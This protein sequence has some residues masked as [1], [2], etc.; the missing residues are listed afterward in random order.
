MVTALLTIVG[1]AKSWLVA[2]I[3]HWF[4]SMWHA[5]FRWSPVGAYARSR[6]SK[7]F[8]LGR[9]LVTAVQTPFQ[10]RMLAGIRVRE[11][12][13]CCRENDV[14]NVDLRVDP[15]RQGLPVNFLT[16]RWRVRNCGGVRITRVRNWIR[17]RVLSRNAFVIH[18]VLK[19]LLEFQA[20]CR[21]KIL[22]FIRVCNVRLLH[23]VRQMCES[24][25]VVSTV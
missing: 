5:L 24:E 23:Y 8:S 10:M 22:H 3:L 6:R 18:V 15:S 14:I 21:N 17:S 20:S 25:T 2:L 9:A 19:S 13:R 7:C 16:T 11:R 12:P 1:S 4:Q